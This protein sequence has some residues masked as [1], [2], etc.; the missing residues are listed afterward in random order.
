MKRILLLL[1]AL[2]MLGCGMIQAQQTTKIIKGIVT[3]T[4]GNPVAGAEIRSTG[5]AEITTS[6]ADGAYEM[7]V[8]F[9]LK[10]VTVTSPGYK[11]CQ[12]MLGGKQIYTTK[13]KPLRGRKALLL[14]QQHQNENAEDN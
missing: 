13:L 6:D 5:G 11:E 7:E 1:A 8:P 10:S 3:D 4:S 9:Y 14:R 12:T 2:T